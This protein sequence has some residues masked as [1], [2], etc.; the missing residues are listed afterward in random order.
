M[1]R[2]I[3]WLVAGLLAQQPVDAARP[4][5]DEASRFFELTNLWTVHLTL[6]RENWS[7]MEPARPRGPGMFKPDYPWSSC[8]FECAGQT[9][10]NVAVRFK[11]NSSF[12][13]A[14]GGLKC[15]F[16]LDFN[17]GQKRRS[18]L[19]LKKLSLNNN[20]NDATQFREALAYEAYRRAG[21]PASRTAFARVYLTLTS[22]RTN[23]FLG[24]YTLVEALDG[25]FLKLHFGTKK[26]LLL[27]P[28]GL[29]SLDYLGEDWRAYTNRY[30]PKTDVQPAD[31]QRFIAL[32]KLIAEADD[33]TLERE[34]PAR[35][36]LENFLR[37][38][39]LTAVL[40]NYDSFV[41]NGHNYYLF[42]PAGEGKAA[43]IPW[44]LNEAFG[45]HP[46]AG[47][48]QAQAELSALRPQ[49]GPNRLIE[50]VL[51]N[52]NWAAA[53]RREVGAALSNAC[54][55]ARLSA[56]AERLARITQE[57]VFAE[58][59]LAKAAFQRI[60]LGQTN[61]ALPERQPNRPPPGLGVGPRP[62]FGPL[63][64]VGGE[65][66]PLRDW[67][68]L[69][70]RNVGDQLAG[71]RTGRMARL[72]NFPAGPGRGGGPPRDGPADPIGDNL[73]PPELVLEQQEAIGLSAEQRSSI[74]DTL[75]RMQ[76]RLQEAERRVEEEV[77]KLGSMLKED[78]VDEH[79][80]LLQS[81]KVADAE[82][83][84]RRTHLGLLTAIKNTLSS[85]QQA[86]L[87]ELKAK[88]APSRQERPRA[89]VDDLL[90]VG[91][92]FLVFDGHDGQSRTEAGPGLV[93]ELLGGVISIS[94]GTACSAA[95]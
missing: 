5:A 10:A 11:G 7:A 6:S 49:A 68:T 93:A 43:F 21:V 31:A 33:A 34:L 54:A 4:S 66:M 24:L 44:D 91:W 20:F 60:A 19:G 42:Q 74:E 39:A 9:L 8:T 90:S 84:L 57:T 28:E 88:F 78:R 69:R 48:R 16:K 51:A 23:E 50:R 83:E 3:L 15:P 92:A 77:A 45:G 32:T 41:G 35:L 59:A 53:Y 52:S 95:S 63:P 18:F 70:A 14:R 38:V 71:K 25:D 55:P 36:D 73:F 26:G 2:P 67:I 94:E 81:D 40:A 82:K 58:S 12:N 29:R 65:A 30:D 89:T 72:Q 76:P 46:M 1:W 64:G 87:K 62:G 27:K 85:E 37:Y 13:S 86:K 80:V 17:R 56:Q 47:A 75:Q 22:E 79:K 61:V